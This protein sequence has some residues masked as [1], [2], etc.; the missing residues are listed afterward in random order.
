VLPPPASFAQRT[1]PLVQLAQRTAALAQFAQRT[2]PLVQRTAELAQRTAALAQRTFSLSQSATSFVPQ[3]YSD[4]K[5]EGI[6]KDYKV[7]HDDNQLRYND[8]MVADTFNSAW[9]LDPPP[10]APEDFRPIPDTTPE[11][12]STSPDVLGCEQCSAGSPGSSIH[13]PDLYSDPIDGKQ[14]CDYCWNEWDEWVALSQYTPTRNVMTSDN[15][16]PKNRHIRFD[17]DDNYHSLWE[18][19]MLSP[20]VNTTTSS[21]SSATWSDTS[22][23]SIEEDGWDSMCEY[24]VQYNMLHS[25]YGWD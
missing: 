8:S 4:S 11:F 3:Y 24:N 20:D 12:M 14:Y 1:D 15:N 25:Q 5:E 7:G 17:V 16:E 23:G 2:D 22:P 13:D 21:V 10:P 6:L 19:P 18:T 9:G